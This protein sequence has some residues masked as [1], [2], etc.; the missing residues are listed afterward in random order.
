[1]SLFRLPPTTQHLLHIPLLFPC[2]LNT[3]ISPSNQPFSL[4]HHTLL[5]LTQRRRIMMA[6]SNTVVGMTWKARQKKHYASHHHISFLNLQSIRKS[7]TV[8]RCA[9]DRRGIH[10][11]HIKHQAKGW[12]KSMQS[13]RVGDIFL[14]NRRHKK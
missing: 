10:I 5:L 13:P 14:A 3:L 1:M 6:A 11:K 12:K 8:Y 9:R 4:S 2:V 7:F